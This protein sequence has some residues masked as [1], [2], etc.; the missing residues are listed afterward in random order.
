MCERGAFCDGWEPAAGVW[1][2]P[3]G[4]AAWLKKTE[5][6]HG[7]S[8]QWGAIAGNPCPQIH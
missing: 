5:K 6:G 2:K 3:E 1:E 4:M 8:K 7:R